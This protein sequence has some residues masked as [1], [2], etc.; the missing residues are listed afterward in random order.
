MVAEFVIRV[1]LGLPDA[2][3]GTDPRGSARMD[4]L[5]T[6]GWHPLD[7]EGGPEGALVGGAERVERGP[8]TMIGMARLNNRAEIR[9]HLGDPEP[10]LSDLALLARL[11]QAEGPD[12]PR[13]VSGAFAVVV[14]DAETGQGS[15]YRDHFG[16][17]PFVYC[18]HAGHLTCGSDLRAVLHLSGL[19][20]ARDTTRIADYIMGRE[21]DRDRTGFAG[22]A[23]L[24]AAH[25]LHWGGEAAPEVRRY[26]RLSLP[27]PIPPEAAVAGFRSRLEAAT[28]ACVD[29][30]DGVGAM[31]SGGL[32]S[33]SL[34]GLA[35]HALEARGAPPL[36]TLSF[37]YG[38]KPYDESRYIAAANAAFRTTP[39]LVP[40][41]SP[42]RLTEMPRIV[43]EQ[44]DLFLGYGLQKAR[45]IYY[46]ARD[47]GLT[48]LIDGHGGDEVVSHGYGRLTELAA[49][50]RW[51]RLFVELRGASR[52][53]G[54][55]VW[56]TYL[57]KIAQHGGWPPGH[58]VR[59]LLMRI[60]RRLAP[61]DS[62]VALP[63]SA[64][65]LLAADLRDSPDL[66]GRYDP[67]PPSGDQADRLR[68]EAR[69]HLDNL[70]APLMEH[71]F[72]VLHR[73]ATPA[74]I[75]PSY[76]F[77]DRRL[78]EFCLS[79][80]AEVKLR[81]GA[82][83]WVLREAMTGVLPEQIRTRTTKAEFTGEFQEAIRLYLAEGGAP[84]FEGLEEFVDPDAAGR[85]ERHMRDVP[86]GDSTACRM[87]WR[88]LVLRDWLRAFARWQD[89]QKSGDLL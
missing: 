57:T 40:V 23:R 79:M 18:T 7:A 56:D 66:A 52:V 76:P 55:P 42:P 80:P 36:P 78:V 13:L 33:S 14:L 15:G 4:R 46:A 83:R 1:P 82:T 84:C 54:T 74:G 49:G 3:D 50:R 37:T 2:A 70:D 16:I 67:T 68:A 86:D 65:D 19:P 73:T 62:R 20:L 32:D 35:A 72:E 29:P 77:F 71:A 87:W 28:E 39:H 27:E 5:R 30:P 45:G 41:T 85:L 26:W 11:R 24:P 38:D 69:A 21:I 9:T 89:Q 81:D 59:R 22:L 47:R 31:L 58:P 75:S 43:E 61:A 88:L 63:V 60:A 6:R 51:I 53:H 44:M 12:F 48:G 34:A 64:R 17:L 10:G 25:G 8:L